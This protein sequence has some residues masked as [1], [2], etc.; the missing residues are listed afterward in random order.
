[1]AGPFYAILTADGQDKLADALATSSTVLITHVAVGDGNGAPI[2]PDPL[3]TSLV[4]E[5]ARV[6]VNAIT[7]DPST[8]NRVLVEGLFPVDVGGF[9]IREAAL[10][11][12]DGL[13]IA[14]ASYPDIYKPLVAD[15]AA[16]AE[17]IRIPLEYLGITS[18]VVLTVDNSTI[19]ATRQYADDAEQA[20]QEYADAADD[21]LLDAL[22]L[23][24]HFTGSAIGTDHWKTNSVAGS[25]A[26][27]L[28]TDTNASGVALLAA[29]GSDGTA[30]I[31]VVLGGLGTK[32][33]KARARLKAGTLGGGAS[34][35]KWIIGD[36]TLAGNA[37]VLE[38]IVGQA[39]WQA[40]KV[41]AGV[42]TTHDTGVAV[43]TSGYQ[44][45]EI[46]RVGGVITFLIDSSTGWTQTVSLDLSA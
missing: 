28:D 44:V 17:Y 10:F 3:M 24:D 21:Y 9:T 27:T 37:L 13:M 19:M 7:I 34:S 41:V 23:S 36:P 16:V 35:A 39:N 26:V 33:F 43:N 25:G 45:L 2:T 14:I 40:V 32:D 15:G 4:N 11:D 5:R 31:G 29:T 8:S 20:A 6:A 30:K 1:M 18:G 22:V 12:T 38:R 42:A 46:K